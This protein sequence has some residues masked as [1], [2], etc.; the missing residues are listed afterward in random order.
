M[1]IFRPAFGLKMFF[2]GF[3]NIHVSLI[4]WIFMFISHIMVFVIFNL[5]ARARREVSFIGKYIN[6][7]AHT[8]CVYNF[9]LESNPGDLGRKMT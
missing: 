4:L 9:H 8:K 2:R 3:E 7:H 6:A 1:N 5:W